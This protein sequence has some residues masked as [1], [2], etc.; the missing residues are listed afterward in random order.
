MRLYLITE[1]CNGKKFIC[2]GKALADSHCDFM[3][4]I[5]SDEYLE[6]DTKRRILIKSIE[7]FFEPN[8]PPVYVRFY[9][10]DQDK[11]KVYSTIDLLGIE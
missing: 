3:R 9:F 8:C 2:N 1:S 6:E 11:I 10:Q 4:R 5:V 7:L